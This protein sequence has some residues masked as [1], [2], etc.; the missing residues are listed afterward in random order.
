MDHRECRKRI[1]ELEDDLDYIIGR[2]EDLNHEVKKLQDKY[3]NIYKVFMKNTKAAMDMN[4]ENAQL[5]AGIEKIS[6][7]FLTN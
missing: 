5:N 1:G 2:K 6:S 3:D 7:K 4:V